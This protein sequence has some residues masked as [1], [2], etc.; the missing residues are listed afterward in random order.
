M[1][2]GPC[3]LIEVTLNKTR[4]TRRYLYSALI[5]VYHYS[6]EIRK[7]FN[8]ITRAFDNQIEFINRFLHPLYSLEYYW[9]PSLSFYLKCIVFWQ[10]N[11]TERWR[12][13]AERAEEAASAT[14]KPSALLS[15]FFSS[16]LS[17]TFPHISKSASILL[18]QPSCCAIV[19]PL[20][21]CA[22]SMPTLVS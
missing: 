22:I 4:S 12:P 13:Q 10:T 21:D 18:C 16:L 11:R 9:F 5:K 19:S 15:T 14:R 6:L 2:L 7:S 20:G 3:K 17:T 8:K 1:C